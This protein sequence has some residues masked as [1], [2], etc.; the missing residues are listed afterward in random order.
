[1]SVLR[2]ARALRSGLKPL[3]RIRR[4]E[5]GAAAVEFG[6]LAF[7]FFLILFSIIE[8]SLVFFANQIMDNAVSDAARM[9]RTGQAQAASF[10]AAEFKTQ[11]CNGLIGLFDCAGGNLYIDVRTFNTFASV[12]I[13]D[14]I[15]GDDE[16]DDTSFAYD[17]G[18]PE[19]IVVVR[20]YYEWPLFTN[21]IQTGF[22]NLAS[23]NRLIASVVAFRNEPFPT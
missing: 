19:T 3:R 10:S 22:G 15:N 6:L 21:M 5:K 23:G 20:V 7:P 13:P 14:P 9:I 16:V 18:G 8:I 1:M 2:I 4:D 11:V 17:D 12:T